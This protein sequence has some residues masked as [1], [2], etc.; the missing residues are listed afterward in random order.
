M[1]LGSARYG[2]QYTKK[3][4]F[5]LKD[6][7]TVFRILPPMG[8]LADKGIWS[9][10]HSV[11]Y[12]YKNSEGKLRTFISPL[13][14]NRTN[15]MIEKPD[16]AL[17]L[18]NKIKAQVDAAKAAG[19]KATADRL[20][21]YA[22]G[23]KS[24]FNLDKNHYVNAM[25]LQGNIGVLKLRHKAK[26]ALDATIKSLRAQGIDPLSP[27]DGRFFV[28][29]R[30]GN[31]L[32]TTF[33]VEVYGEKIDVAG[34]GVVTKQVVHKL[35]S[36][37]VD[38]LEAE[39]VNLDKIFKKLT[40]EEV[41][42]IVSSV[43][44]KT[45]I[46]PAVDALFGATPDQGPDGEDEDEGATQYSAP[47]TSQAASAAATPQASAPTTSAPAATPIQQAA[48]IQQAPAAAASTAP[49]TA[50]AVSSQSDLAFLAELSSQ[51]GVKLG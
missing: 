17:D 13:V 26:L 2:A 12:G 42:Q 27:E 19:D 31:A 32:D 11:H 7:E 47:T 22:G 49:T 41:Q 34:I 38:R 24:R 20:M 36:D 39:A 40:S 28:F 44:L 25:D 10:Y 30:A 51:L 35:T 45:G 4:Y 21:E 50:Q 1:K 48:P 16:A 5:K 15:K 37:I 33:Q 23:P 29:R 9:V 3:K 18:I 14:V 6:G 43:D 8:D 46:S